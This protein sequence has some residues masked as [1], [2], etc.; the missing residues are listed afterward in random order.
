M[1]GKDS[2]RIAIRA[3]VGSNDTIWANNTFAAA[4]RGRK[5]CEPD[6]GKQD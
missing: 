4:T 5:V 6:M 3:P 1:G 2:G